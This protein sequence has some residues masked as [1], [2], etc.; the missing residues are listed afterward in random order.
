MCRSPMHC[1]PSIGE[2]DT[3]LDQARRVDHACSEVLEG[4]TELRIMLCKEKRSGG[5]LGTSVVAACG[6]CP[7]FT[8]WEYTAAA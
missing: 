5:N 2:P 8:S 4:A 3:V 1:L 6:A 7:A